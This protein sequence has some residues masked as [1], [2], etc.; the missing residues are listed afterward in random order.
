MKPKKA[1]RRVIIKRKV[2]VTAQQISYKN[3][4]ILAQFVSEQGSIIPRAITCVP[5]KLQRLIS[6]EVKRARH[7]GILQ[8]TQT[9]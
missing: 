8:F 4:L 1:K 6:R 9:V 5:Q 2:K 7:L 3:P